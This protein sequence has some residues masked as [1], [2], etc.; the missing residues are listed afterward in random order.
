VGQKLWANISY[1]RNRAA[2]IKKKLQRHAPVHLRT[3]FKRRVQPAK[4]W[5]NARATPA[6]TRTHPVDVEKHPVWTPRRAPFL[7]QWRSQSPRGAAD[8]AET[9]KAAVRCGHR[10]ARKASIG[11]RGT[12]RGSGPVGPGPA[13]R[14]ITKSPEPKIEETFLNNPGWP[15]FFFFFPVI[16]WG[17]YF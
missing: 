11:H 15:S 2:L 3:E 4:V 7:F 8:F 14:I 13:Q 6:T 16:T 5:A 17:C 12:V 1:F 10:D 9:G